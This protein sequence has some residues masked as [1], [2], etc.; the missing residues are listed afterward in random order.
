MARSLIFKDL[1]L[2]FK[3]SR[4]IVAASIC[5]VSTMLSILLQWHAK[6]VPACRVWIDTLLALYRPLCTFWER[7]K[8]RWIVAA[9]N[10]FVPTEP[11]ILFQWH[12]PF[13]L[14]TCVN[15]IYCWTWYRH[16]YVSYLPLGVQ[17]LIIIQLN[18][19][20]FAFNRNI[21]NKCALY[22]NS[23]MVMFFPIN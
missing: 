19:R 10:L 23:W 17:N 9:T 7:K 18:I 11:S 12:V 14:H 15:L 20:H 6:V 3:K 13:L 1:F 4:I 16:E 8:S 22:V 2:L 5:V 21:M